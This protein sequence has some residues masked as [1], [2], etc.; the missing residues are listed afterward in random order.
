MEFII[1]SDSGYRDSFE[2]S[3]STGT[4][5]PPPSQPRIVISPSQLDWNGSIQM[6]SSPQIAEL[7]TRLESKLNGLESNLGSKLGRVESNLE[8][9]ISDLK[10]KLEAL[11]SNLTT[12]GTK[13]LKLRNLVDEHKKEMHSEVDG[14]LKEMQGMEKRLI[15]R[16]D[17]STESQKTGLDELA[18]SQKTIFDRI[19]ALFKQ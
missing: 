12:H 2:S 14:V 6:A 18:V 5:G 3:G 17:E 16:V 1:T 19:L 13:L 10:V 4:F 8:G 7:F 9:R 11:E 15:D